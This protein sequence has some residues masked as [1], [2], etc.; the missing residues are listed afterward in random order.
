[1]NDP[2][3][4]LIDLEHKT[5]QVA[6]SAPPFGRF[7]GAHWIDATHLLV[8]ASE[9]IDARAR[10]LHLVD[11][12]RVIER[13]Y[14]VLRGA[15]GRVVTSPAAAPAGAPLRAALRGGVLLARSEG[16]APDTD[17]RNDA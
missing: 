8:L 10:R 3:V 14:A 1:M 2:G 15:S 16:A 9:R 4:A 5:M 7:D 6:L 13:G 12:A 17:E 11:P